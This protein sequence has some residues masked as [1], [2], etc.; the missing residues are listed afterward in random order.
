MLTPSPLPGPS[1]PMGAPLT[2]APPPIWVRSAALKCGTASALATKS[3]ITLSCVK[4]KCL[5][6]ASAE[7]V[8]G[9]FVSVTVSPATGAATAST[10]S[11][12]LTGGASVA[13]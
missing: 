4:P 8:H 11:V 9:W 7:N 1:S 10:A 3:L 2:G 6:S 13:R 5:R 12:G